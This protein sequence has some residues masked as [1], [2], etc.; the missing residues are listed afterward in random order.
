MVLPI[1]F[2]NKRYRIDGSSR[3]LWSFRRLSHRVHFSNRVDYHWS[4]V[5]SSPW[6]FR[7]FNRRLIV[8]HCQW[9]S[10]PSY[11]LSAELSFYCTN[12]RLRHN[13]I[14]ETI[15]LS[16]CLSTGLLLYWAKTRLFH[17]TM[18]PAIPQIMIQLHCPKWVA[19][20]FRI[21]VKM[22]HHTRITWLFCTMVALLR[23]T[24]APLLH[25]SYVLALLH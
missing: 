17:Q 14:V 12:S 1:S 23:R 5:Q 3:Q 20:L 21:R 11:H 7:P 24:K 10:G 15:C 25:R 22:S 8:P 18:V 9:S 13:Y 4:V 19:T 2:R 6:T 16:L